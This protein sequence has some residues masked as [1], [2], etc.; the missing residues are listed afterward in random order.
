MNP[1]VVGERRCT[2]CSFYPIVGAIHESPAVKGAKMFCLFSSAVITFASPLRG[3]KGGVF[4]NTKMHRLCVI[5][6]G[7]RYAR[8]RTA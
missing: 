2:V 3:G 1:A 5:L 7:G 8:S 6:S 4:V